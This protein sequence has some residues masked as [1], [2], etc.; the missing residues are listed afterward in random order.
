MGI[1]RRRAEPSDQCWYSPCEWEGEHLRT[2]HC[3]KE[4]WQDQ[5]GDLKPKVP[6]RGIL[7]ISEMGLPSCPCHKQS[8]G[9]VQGNGVLAWTQ[10]WKSEHSS[11]C[12]WFIILPALGDL[13]G[14]PSWLPPHCREDLDHKELITA[15]DEMLMLIWLILRAGWFWSLYS[16]LGEKD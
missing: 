2:Q 5:Q 16:N 3:S 11:W 4:V 1:W 14:I 9:T 15:I 6:F 7:C 13:G 8:P 12:L 10:W